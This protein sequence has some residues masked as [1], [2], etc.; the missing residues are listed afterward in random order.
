MN[1]T[2][3]RVSLDE[4][5]AAL[6]KAVSRRWWVSVLRWIAFTLLPAA[7]VSAIA[8]YGETLM[9]A[10]ISLQAVVTKERSP[11]SGVMQYHV[12]ISNTGDKAAD[13]V[14]GFAEF[15]FEGTIV[16]LS[17]EH[18]FLN[19]SFVVDENGV[20]KDKKFC[21]GQTTC[22]IKFGNLY[23]YGGKVN[24]RF[25]SEGLMAFRPEIQYGGKPPK[26]WLCVNVR[27]ALQ[28]SCKN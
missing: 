25:R 15:W 19:G 18:A 12:A 10:S 7:A 5:V 20:E 17:A 28:R 13:Q 1:E 14:K 6:E 23:P 4:R 3:Q 11:T 21:V 8:V 22:R 26:E 24:L 27:D 2:K 9:A 16:G